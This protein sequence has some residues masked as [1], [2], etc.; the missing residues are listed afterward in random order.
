MCQALM[1]PGPLCPL[2]SSLSR[3]P[4]K[5]AGI[6]HVFKL[7]RGKAG[8]QR[9]LR[10]RPCTASVQRGQRASKWQGDRRSCRRGGGCFSKRESLA[11]GVTCGHCGGLP[12]FG[13]AL[14]SEEFVA[15]ALPL[16]GPYR[17]PWRPFLHFSSLSKLAQPQCH[18]LPV[19]SGA[20]LVPQ[21]N[22]FALP[23]DHPGHGQSSSQGT[24]GQLICC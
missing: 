8:C 3:Q 20:W 17:L 6:I 11:A 14:C 22:S 7:P 15:S 13:A 24:V 12:A 18:S 9:S 21:Q 19:T 2:S 5:A 23:S 4:R 1:V 10:G 16:A